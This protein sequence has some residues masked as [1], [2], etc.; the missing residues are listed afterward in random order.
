MRR[1]SKNLPRRIRHTRPGRLTVSTML[2][3]TP[4]GPFARLRIRAETDYWRERKL[5]RHRSFPTRGT[6]LLR[7]G[8]H[9]DRKYIMRNGTSDPVRNRWFYCDLVMQNH[10]EKAAVHRQSMAVVIDKA[11]PLEL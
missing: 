8:I 11:K 7:N 6:T 1:A 10:V 2:P 9:V 3:T 5:G 4:K